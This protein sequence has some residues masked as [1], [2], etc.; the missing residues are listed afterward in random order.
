MALNFLHFNDKSLRSCC[1]G[2]VML[3]AFTLIYLPPPPQF[4]LLTGNWLHA[5]PTTL[6]ESH[7]CKRNSSAWPAPLCIFWWGGVNFN[8]LLVTLTPKQ[9]H[10]PDN[11]LIHW[12]GFRLPCSVFIIQVGRRNEQEIWATKTC[13][14]FYVSETAN[15]AQKGIS[16]STMLTVFEIYFIHRP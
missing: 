11:W 2:L 8:I 9:K 12:S 7:V 14:M 15:S 5:S 6:W 3:L 10:H 4:P 1:V 13:C 16:H